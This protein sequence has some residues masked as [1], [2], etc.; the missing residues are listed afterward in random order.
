M[1][2]DIHELL[3][4][5]QRLADCDTWYSGVL[6]RFLLI[7]LNG[8]NYCFY[9]KAKGLPVDF[10]DPVEGNFM[11]TEAA[12]VVDKGDKTNPN[13]Q[14]VVEVIIKNAR[15]EL[16]QYYPVALYK[17]ETVS[18]ENKPANPKQFP[19]ALTV[20]LLQKHQKLVK[21]E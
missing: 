11:L 14:K 16:L 19:E 3:R 18:A 6:Q 17:G 7:Q 2:Y 1:L 13:A 4:Y 21:G 15:P 10:I 5:L 20:E 9:A 12:A 8:E